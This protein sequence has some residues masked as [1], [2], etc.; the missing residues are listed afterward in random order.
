MLFWCAPTQICSRKKQE[1][2]FVKLSLPLFCGA[3]IFIGEAKSQRAKHRIICK[4][5]CAACKDVHIMMSIC[6][7]FA[8]ADIDSQLQQTQRCTTSP[9]QLCF[10]ITGGTCKVLTLLACCAITSLCNGH[11]FVDCNPVR[12]FAFSRSSR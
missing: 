10:A 11:T 8:D 3:H 2:P 9:W 7:S 1:V 4:Q 5:T 12:F 6:L